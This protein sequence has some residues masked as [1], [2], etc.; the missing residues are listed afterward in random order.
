MDILHPR[1]CETRGYEQYHEFCIASVEGDSPA[2]ALLAAY[3]AA[4]KE[5]RR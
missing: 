4:V 1:R 5:G 2:E 3:I